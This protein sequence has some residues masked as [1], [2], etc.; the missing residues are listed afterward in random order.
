MG[1]FEFLKQKKFY[2]HLLI[3][4]LLFFVLMWITFR[5]LDGYTRHDKVYTMPNFI[6]QNYLEVQEEYDHDF[7]FIL[8]DSVYPKGEEPGSIVQQDPLPDSKVKKG[9]NVYCIIVAV[10]PE[11]TE[12]PNLKNLS[13]RQ[14]VGTLESN[15]LEVDKLIY[16]DYFAKNA[17]IEQLYQGQVIESGTE[18]VKG[19]KIS[20]RVGFGQD[21]KKIEI[22]NLIGRPAV[23]VK[24]LLNVAGLNLGEEFFDDSDSLQYMKVSKMKPG[25]SSALVEAGTFVNIWYRSSKKFD[26]DKEYKNLLH[27]DSINNK[28]SLEEIEEIEEEAEENIE[29]TDI[30]YEDEF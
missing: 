16:E 4:I 1:H 20:L 28:P 6:G 30:E 27:E 26:F 14:A 13:L 11:K 24:R 7:N 18:I 19:S 17:V 23:E 9:R 22:P 12:M 5:S 29:T 21:K 3:I 8:I 25:P 10:M 2:I 15:G